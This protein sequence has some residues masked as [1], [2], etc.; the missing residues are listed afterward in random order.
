M[1]FEPVARTFLAVL[2]MLA[3][4]CASPSP[5]G[6]EERLL[7]DRTAIA[8]RS[9]AMFEA[10]RTG[11]RKALDELMG[12]DFRYLSSTGKQDRAKG[13][14]INLQAGVEVLE[15]TIVNPRVTPIT[16]DVAVLHYFAHQRL[17]KRGEGAIICP[18]SGSMEAWR[19]EGGSWRITAR[20]EWLVSWDSGPQCSVPSPH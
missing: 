18:Y 2:A 11:D 16:A 6:A 14:E 10:E 5:G 8:E 15:Y 9:R 20:T 19:R 4:G 3:G 1:A 17:R 7:A 12:E 13:E